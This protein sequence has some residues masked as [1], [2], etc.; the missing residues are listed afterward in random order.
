MKS[1]YFAAYAWGVLV[2]NIGII[3]WGAFVRISGSGAGCGR[4]W[5]LCHGE[6]IPAAAAPATLIELTHRLSS[7]LALLLVVGLLVWSIR[8]YQRGAAV[9][10]AAWFA[11]GFIVLEA[12]IG[13][14]LVLLELV[15]DNASVARAVWMILH[16]SNTLFLLAS[17][18]WCAW[19]ASG[20]AVMRSRPVG[21]VGIALGGALVGMLLLSASGAVA[22]LGS[23]LFPASSLAAGIQQDLSATAHIL[24]RL[25]ILHPVLSVLAS[26]Y[27][28]IIAWLFYQRTPTT[29]MR[30]LATLLTILIGVQLV[31]GVLNLVLLTP[32]GL[33]LLHLLLHSLIWGTLVLLASE[34]LAWPFSHQELA[35]QVEPAAFGMPPAAQGVSHSAGGSVGDLLTD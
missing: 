11:L 27:L 2:Y 28:V 4:D 33:Q 24:I 19:W 35:Q 20:H 22:A 29:L 21:L 14:G 25:R 1:K 17:L 16:L 34:V 9:R 3:L 31:I 7:G 13:A 30:Q 8:L 15:A 26:F 10:R 5:P 6:L 12:L 23:T 18:T 32:A